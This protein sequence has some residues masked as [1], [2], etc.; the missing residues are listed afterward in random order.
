M[1]TADREAGAGRESAAGLARSLTVARHQDVAPIRVTPWRDARVSFAVPLAARGAAADVLDLLDDPE[2]HFSAGLRRGHLAL[3]PSPLALTR[4]VLSWEWSVDA[5]DFVVHS[6][7]ATPFD[8]AQRSR[9]ER[10]MRASAVRL[11]A[12]QHDID[13]AASD[14]AGRVARGDGVESAA[15]VAI[16]GAAHDDD[17]P[18][19]VVIGTALASTVDPAT[20]LVDVR[21]P[22]PT[23]PGWEV[24]VDARNGDT[25]G[26]RQ[27]L[28]RDGEPY[29]FSYF[30]ADHVDEVTPGD[31][32]HWH[33]QHI[34]RQM[35]DEDIRQV[36]VH[37]MSGLEAPASVRYP[38]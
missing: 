6:F 9:L 11:V 2:L 28:Q 4:V 23:D 32:V 17:G 33:D 24:F 20:R 16:G 34:Q 30:V 31:L 19:E 12:A 29:A 35:L 26:Y 5:A 37:L 1:S 21:L 13:T 25:L 10:W 18:V 14:T 3:L 38:R 7:E 36:M 15:Q 8:T 22:D 27:T